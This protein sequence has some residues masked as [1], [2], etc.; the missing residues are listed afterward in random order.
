MNVVLGVLILERDSSG[1]GMTS[2]ERL[3]VGSPTAPLCLRFRKNFP[4]KSG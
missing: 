3:G 1:C 4:A 2:G